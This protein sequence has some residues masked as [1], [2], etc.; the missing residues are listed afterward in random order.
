M[1][2]DVVIRPIHDK[3]RPAAAGLNKSKQDYTKRLHDSSLVVSTSAEF[4]VHALASI[5]RPRGHRAEFI[6]QSVCA[7]LEMAL[8]SSAGCRLGL[9]R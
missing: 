4:A 3:D 7:P 1:M 2:R 8:A 5:I 6:S 9:L